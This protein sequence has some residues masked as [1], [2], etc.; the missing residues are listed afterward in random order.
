MSVWP[1][2]SINWSCDTCSIELDSNI[3]ICRKSNT[4]NVS[5]TCCF[6][7]AYSQANLILFPKMMFSNIIYTSLLRQCDWHSTI[8]FMLSTCALFNQVCHFQRE[9]T[10]KCGQCLVSIKFKCFMWCFYDG[11]IRI[12]WNMPLTRTRKLKS[13]QTTSGFHAAAAAI[14]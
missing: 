2:I 1:K 7:N 13:T 11:E 5:L 10:I 3:Q 9:P 8:N 14:S 6:S 12:V 4:D